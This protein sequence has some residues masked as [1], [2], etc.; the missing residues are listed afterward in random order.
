LNEDALLKTPIQVP[1]VETRQTIHERL[2]DC[3]EHEW[4]DYANRMIILN[5]MKEELH[6]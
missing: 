1:G 4:N 5:S 3:A 6:E 2:L